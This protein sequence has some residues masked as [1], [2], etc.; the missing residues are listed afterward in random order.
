[1]HANFGYG[2]ETVTAAVAATRENNASFLMGRSEGVA[3]PY[4]KPRTTPGR[5]S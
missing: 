5:S 3:A 1:M 4:D 2:S